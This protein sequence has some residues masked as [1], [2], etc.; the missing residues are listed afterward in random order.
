MSNS[1]SK[2]EP[3][4]CDACSTPREII[5][6]D[7]PFQR[8]EHD[9]PVKRWVHVA[10]PC[11]IKAL[12]DAKLEQLQRE[13]RLRIDKALRLSSAHE[14][15]KDMRFSNYRKREGNE[16]IY[17]EVLKA[18]EEFKERGKLGLFAFGETG[19][20]KTHITAAG[21][22][23]LIEQGVSVI[24]LTEK[25]L[26]ARLA[27]TKNFKN[28]ESLTEIL[29]ACMEADL[30][31]WDDFMSSQRLSNDERDWIFQIVNGRERANR[32]IWFTS[33]LTPQEFMDDA[34]KY[35]LDDKGR[36]WGRIIGNSISVIN[37]AKDHR[38]MAAMAR[39]VNVPIEQFEQ[40][41][42]RYL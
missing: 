9:Q 11:R 10:C 27:A 18:V 12:E 21:G 28:N 16:N 31:I 17:A 24:F 23:A 14:D 2:P 15:I 37:R 41:P 13:K 6:I 42:T 33:N 26:F 8:D 19:N 29:N 39:M 25:D 40:D 30:L 20:G 36:T 22:N 35:V 1:L 4:L 7:H 3:Q 5:Q 32:P 38:K 34:P